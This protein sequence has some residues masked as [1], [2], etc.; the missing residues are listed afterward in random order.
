MTDDV[1][2]LVGAPS[3]VFDSYGNQR[4]VESYRTVFCRIRSVA[5]SE[6]Y[7]AAQNDLHPEYVFILQNYKDYL[8]E[9][10]LLYTDWSGRERR[11][12]IVRTYRSPDDDSIEL[13]AEER[14]GAQRT[15]GDEDGD[16][17]V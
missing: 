14:I 3:E 17:V 2:Q 12:T 15:G 8:G 5:R 16:A 9:R 13:T 7:Q 6:F 10:E 1:I 4:L 11:Y